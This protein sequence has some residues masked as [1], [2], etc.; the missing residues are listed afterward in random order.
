MKRPY[1]AAETTPARLIPRVLERMTNSLGLLRASGRLDKARSLL[2]AYYGNGTDAT[3]DSSQ[4]RDAGEDGE[5][6]EL[7]VNGVR[8]VINNT[9]SL[10][11]GQPLKMKARARNEDA[12]ALAQTRFAEFLLESTEHQSGSDEMEVACV[13]GGLLASAWALGQA[14]R[15]KDGK[16]WARDESGKPVFEGDI[17]L[18]V[19]PPWR[20]AFDMAA[21]N[22]NARKWGLFRLPASRWDTASQLDVDDETFNALPPEQRADAEKRRELA[23]KIRSH[24]TEGPAQSIVPAPWSTTNGSTASALDALL[25]EMLPAEDVVWVWE[26]RH[27]KTAALPRG[28]LVRFVEPDLI[29]WDSL[30]EGVDY[31]YEELH[32]YE[33]APERAVAGTAGHTGAFDLGGLQEFMD[34]CTASIATTA[35]INGQMHLW[36]GD[37][38]PPQV[39]DLSSGNTVIQ[40]PT[41]PVPLEYPALKPELLEV[42]EWVST[43]ANQAMA[44]N[45]V[46]MGRPDKG[47]PASAQALQRAQAQQFHAVSQAARVE[48]R[49][50]NANGKLRLFKQFARTPRVATLGGAG[51]RYEVREWQREDLEDVE[52]YEVEPI[53]PASGTFEGRQAMM[54]YLAGTGVFQQRPDAL[55]TYMQTGSL[56]AVTASMT[57]QR[58]L[59][60]ANVALLQKGI[61]PPPVDMNASLQSGSPV[62]VEPPDGGEVLLLL[63]SDPHHLAIPAYAGVLASPS[64]RRDPKMTRACQEAI[65]LSLEFWAALTPDESAAFGIP[66][67]PSQ[68]AM[69]TPSM[70][71]THS[72]TPDEP[73]N[74]A[75]QV[76]GVKLP[77]PPDNP[78]TG[79]SESASSTGLQ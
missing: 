73:S 38:G 1:W 71:P 21:P 35:N 65:M 64:T 41:M 6:T 57:S 16:E 70:P 78:L 45:D 39:H 10:I 46:V 47:M 42:L 79:A 18:F 11:A 25:G 19:M 69:A 23:E 68:L 61:G 3:R 37:E 51:R 30:T 14:W 8:P 76:E 67:L 72:A 66:P 63:K 7:H 36:T 75:P 55:L 77:A 56:S 4:L 2:S 53:D 13:R 27:L 49:R 31:P 60:E 15:P 22:E 58:E 28:R 40:T 20:Y 24:T 48:L 17:S 43:T 54:E 9:L 44:L 50:R 59:V 34:I 33:F 5:V 52:L 12:R 29:L 62:F 74:P 32:L 26:L